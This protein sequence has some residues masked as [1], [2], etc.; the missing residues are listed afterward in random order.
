MAGNYLADAVLDA[1]END[2]KRKI[3]WQNQ[4]QNQDGAQ[5]QGK[6]AGSVYPKG[7]AGAFREDQS[8]GHGKVAHDEQRQAGPRDL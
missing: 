5:V 8:K 1:G 3:K 4:N 2:E 7:A 6:K